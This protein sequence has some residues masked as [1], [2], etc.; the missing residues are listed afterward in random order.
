MTDRNLH[1]AI[2]AEATGDA[3]E[4]RRLTGL[5]FKAWSPGTAPWTGEEL[6]DV[7]APGDDAI[8]VVDDMGG[9][10]VTFSSIRTYLDFWRP[11]M[12]EA[13][14]EWSITPRGP[15]DIVID[16]SLA[17]ATFAF[18][19]TGRTPVGEAIDLS[20][21]QY[22]THVYRKTDSGWR[23]VHEHLTTAK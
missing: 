1:F 9:R 4:L 6:R 5:W 2:S 19:A 12:A 22:G 18:D 16:G 7:F 21:A 13:A 11:W 17:V 23:L 3:A 15:I 8:R 10:V 20:P 14:A